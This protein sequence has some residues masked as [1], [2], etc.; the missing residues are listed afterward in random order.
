M[1]INSGQCLKTLPG[2]TGWVDSISFSPDGQTLAS[3][4][5]DQTIR[6]WDVATGTLIRQLVGHNGAVFG[7]D[8]SPDGTLLASSSE[9][10]TVKIWGL[11]HE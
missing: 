2:L 4:G 5:T 11:A 8:F 9:D 6:L 7:V 10:N 1:E 3:G